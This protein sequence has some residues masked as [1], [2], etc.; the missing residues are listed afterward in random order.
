MI[1]TQLSDAHIETASQTLAAAFA[2]DPFVRYVLPDDKQFWR[3]W[4]QVC[5]HELK[6]NVGYHASYVA[7]EGRGGVSIWLPPDQSEKRGRMTLFDIVGLTMLLGIGAVQRFMTLGKAVDDA[8]PSEIAQTN[9]YYLSMLGVSPDYQGQGVGG[10]LLQP[11]FEQADA[12]GTLC[13]AEVFNERAVPFYKRHGFEVQPH[14][15]PSSGLTFWTLL[16]RSQS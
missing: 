2:N 12:T 14:S 9:W 4:P 10:K 5:T 6:N 13:Y 11:I 16:R 3:V 8:Q 7:D 1:I 15:E